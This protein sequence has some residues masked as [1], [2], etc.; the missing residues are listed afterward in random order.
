MYLKKPVTFNGSR[1]IYCLS[2]YENYSKFLKFK[3]NN[4][5]KIATLSFELRNTEMALT[6]VQ[7]VE[8][9][10]DIIKKHKP[11]LL[12]CAG[13]A[14]ET[15]VDLVNLATK[16]KSV[17]STTT[18]LV[19]VKNALK[20]DH[21]FPS[22]HK[23][24]VITDSNSIIELGRQYFASSGE[25]NSDNAAELVRNLENNIKNR[26]FKVKE[27]NCLALCC[28]ELNIIQGRD[29]PTVRSKII[30]EA[31][32]NADIVLNPTHDGMANYGTLMKKRGFLSQPMNKRN[33]M[34]ISSSNWNTQKPRQVKIGGVEKH[35]KQSPSGAFMQSV[36]MNG[37][38]KMLDD[39]KFH[40]NERNEYHLRVIDLNLESQ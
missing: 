15:D 31:L 7:R 25:L 14:V 30:E 34:Y 10:A 38:S 9:I 20:G 2:S 18:T 35:I 13:W 3:T 17:G 39:H 28:G 40:D 32:F 37:E 16:C 22:S 24:N 4:L 21:G 27:Y 6:G 33:R 19:E 12:L 8:I 23:M 36:W 1:H 5:M 29:C 11:E 26:M